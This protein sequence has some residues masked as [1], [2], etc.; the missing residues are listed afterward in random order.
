MQPQILQQ[1]IVVFSCSYLPLTRINIKR[2]IALLVAGQAEPLELGT[3]PLW[4]VRSPSIVLQVPPH[5]RLTHSDPKRQ[6]KLPPV[7]RREVFRRD[8][9]T[10]QYCGS[11]TRLT[12]DHVI[13]RSKG[14]LHT[15]EN[16]TT[17]CEPCNSQK[18]NRLLKETGM[19]LRNK[20]KAP[21]HPAIAFA[22][23]FWNE[24][25]TNL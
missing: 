25:K 5:I 2:A 10:C 22:E 11:Q 7:S 16:V 24:Q 6:W 8:N 20:P 14:G 12:L 17:A 3:G 19:A 23:Q 21:I 4:T 15:W 1:Q 13:P 9:H 18:G